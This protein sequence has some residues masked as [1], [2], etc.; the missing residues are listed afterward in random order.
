MFGTTML[1]VLS[2][3]AFSPQIGPNVAAAAKKTLPSKTASSKTA[4]SKTTAPDA[5]STQKRSTPRSASDR[6]KRLPRFFGQLDLDPQQRAKIRALQ[7]KC[8]QQQANLQRQIDKLESQLKKDL[9]K[10]LRTDQR[11]T[12]KK[13]ERPKRTSKKR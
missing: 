4:S 1:A 7:A 8:G 10:L 12:L 6:V 11:R 3:L 9:S 13:L 5:S 2:T